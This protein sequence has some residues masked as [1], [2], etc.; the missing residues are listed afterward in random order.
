MY[1]EHMKGG[2]FLD[3]TLTHLANYG[4]T[5]AMLK[6]DAPVPGYPQIRAD[7]LLTLAADNTQLR[8]VV[9][10]KRAVTNT[11]LGAAIAQARTLAGATNRTPLLIAEYIPTGIAEKLKAQD[12]QFADAA[13]N[14][15]LTGKGTLIW[16]CGRKRPPALAPYRGGAFAAGGIKVLFALLC[17]PALAAAAQRHIA[18]TAG[19][20]LG[21]VPGVL[22]DLAEKGHV[23]G[24]GKSR[25]L[26]YLPRLLD[27]WVTIYAHTLYP[28][29]LLRTL[30]PPN[31]DG[32]ENWN[33]AQYGARWGAEPAAKILV[34]QIHPGNLTLYVKRLPGRL[35]AEQRMVEPAPSDEQGLVH[36]R[37]NFW[38]NG[39][40]ET[41]EPPTVH[42]LLVY[43]D[44]LATGDGRCIETAELVRETHLARL[45]EHD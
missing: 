44:L 14:A 23:L 45:L 12:Q 35:I 33:I 24:K 34:G 5:V 32:W 27:E 1:S 17:N 6:A 29:T 28:R 16:V 20:A 22:R 41:P 3:R 42:P 7:A 21:T 11:T 9:E 37:E 18:D 43:A 38:G 15:Y 26:A 19:V 4:L 13:G 30:A 2:D 40:D 36:F 10:A 25:R 31:L 8:Y 39:A